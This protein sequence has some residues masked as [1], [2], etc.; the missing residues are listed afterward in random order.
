MKYGI[1]TGGG[2]AP[3]LNGIIES[4]ARTLLA[5]GHELVGSVDGFEGI[6]HGQFKSIT[7]ENTEG[8]H[9]IAGTFLGTSNKSRI[10][11]LRDKFI[12]GFRAMGAEGL[13]VA[14][15][16]GTF[17]ALSHFH[18]EI[19]IIAVPKTIDNDLQGT[20]VTFGFDTACSVVSEAVDALRTTAHAHS[21]IMI[22]EAMGRTAGWIALGGGLSSY[23]DAILVPERPFNREK[24]LAFVRAQRA[25]PRRGLVMVVCE[26]AAAEGEDAK[27]AFLVKESVQAE[28]YGGIAQ[29]LA[30]WLEAETGWES[31][32]VVL[33]HLQRSRAPTTTDRFLTAAM[34]VEAAQLALAGRWHRAVVYRDGRVR[35]VPLTEILGPAR[36]I[37]ADHRW[38]RLAESLGIFL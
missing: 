29:T 4:V 28:R 5:Q 17:S 33:G 23:A 27:V 26:S 31:R 35:D 19:P 25:K 12:G 22:V 21:R 3:G 7:R 37:P 8:I 38:L 9:A 24:L 20:D 34:G 30:H 36:R 16:D 13:I 6:L 15:G 11:N 32:A 14:G 1:L 18:Q 2:D 10:E